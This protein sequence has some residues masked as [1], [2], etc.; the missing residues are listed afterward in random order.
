MNDGEMS[1]RLDAVNTASTAAQVAA[2]VALRFF[3]RDVFDLHDRFEQDRFALFK[4]IFHREDRRQFE[5][6]LAGIDFVEASI[7]DVHFNIDHGIT[8]ENTV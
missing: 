3:W 1:A 8:A 6:E 2:D 7:N 5:S 4:A